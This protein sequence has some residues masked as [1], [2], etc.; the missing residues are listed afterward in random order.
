MAGY[1]WFFPFTGLVEDSPIFIGKL[2]YD[3]GHEYI[4]EELTFNASIKFM[5]RRFIRFRTMPWGITS[6][7]ESLS[8]RATRL[9]FMHGN[10]FSRIDYISLKVHDLIR[11]VMRT[12]PR[13]NYNG[14]TTMIT[15]KN[16]DTADYLENSIGPKSFLSNDSIR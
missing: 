3:Q 11:S 2:S 1:K 6:L 8:H 12:S 14:I 16:A 5:M 10:V 4:V 7:R 13:N 15:F 9:R